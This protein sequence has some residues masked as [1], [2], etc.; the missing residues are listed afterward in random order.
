[1]VHQHRSVLV[2]GLCA[3]NRYNLVEEQHLLLVSEARN[4]I[5]CEA[6]APLEGIGVAAQDRKQESFTVAKA[7]SDVDAEGGAEGAVV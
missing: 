1:M 3:L 2:V 5:H 7:V 4:P 6:D